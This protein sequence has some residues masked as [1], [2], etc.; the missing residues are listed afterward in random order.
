MNKTWLKQLRFPHV[1][2]MR[3]SKAGKMFILENILI[4]IDFWIGLSMDQNIFLLTGSYG[5]SFV[6]I[7]LGRNHEKQQ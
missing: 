7:F 3:N 2:Y 6:K 1:F 5:L 4:E